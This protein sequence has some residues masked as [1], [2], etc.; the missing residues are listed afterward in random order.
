MGILGQPPNEKQMKTDEWPDSVKE[1]LFAERIQGVPRSFIREILKASLDPAVISF[2]GGLPNPD[3]FPVREIEESTRKVF[4]TGGANVLQYSTSEGDPELR[5]L[6]AD[7]Y[8]ETKGLLLSPD[9]IIIT[10]GS[11]QGIDLLAKVFLDK[12]DTVLMEEPGYLGAIQSLSLYQPFFSAVPVG[13]SGMDVEALESVSRPAS[14]KMLYTVP[15]FQNPSGITYTEKNRGQVAAVARTN[16]FIVVEDDP[17]GELRFAGSPARSFYHYLPGQSV[18]LGSFSKVVA[19]GLRLGWIVAPKWISEKLLIAKQAADLHSS[20][21]TQ[22]IIC[23]FLKAHDLDRHIQA[24]TS[25]YGSQCQAMV[26]AIGREFPKEIRFTD[27]QGGMFLW[28]RLPGA[29]CSMALFNEAVKEN[30]V[31]VPGEPFY[32]RSGSQP[33]F[34]LNFSCVDQQAIEEGVGRMTKALKRFL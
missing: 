6:I 22:K 23:E 3:F 24:I 1:Q 27:P 20:S 29:K 16:G 34:R 2:A 17:Y 31:F 18:L 12:G 30:V 5:Q 9:N 28:G 7:R 10:N 8:K 13:E 14:A 33:T 21:F 4:E 25:R 19:P 26:E 11:Q 32:T 15:T